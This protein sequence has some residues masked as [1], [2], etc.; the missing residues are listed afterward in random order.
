MFKVLGNAWK[1]ADLRK[2]ILYTLFILLIYRLG[3]VIPVPGTNAAYI[4]SQVENY[5]LLG[6]LNVFSGGGLQNMSIFALGVIP[7][8]NASIIMN[9]LTIAIPAL[10]RMSKEGE[11]GRKKIGRITRYLAVGLGLVQAIGILVSMGS[12]AVQST[13]IFNYITIILCLTAGTALI[14]WLGE[15]INEKGIGNGISLLIF[16]G[17]VAKLPSEIITLCTNVFSGN[18]SAWILVAFV[19]AA[20]VIIAALTF[21]DLGERR[22]PVQYAKRVVGRKQYGGQSTFIPMKVNQSGVMPLIFA[23]T[24]VQIP[25]MIAQFV[26]DSGFAS[27]VNRFLG[28]G[29]WLYA[30]IYFV[31]ILFFSYFYAQ[32]AFNPVD[33]SKNIQQY[34]GFIPGIRPGRPTSDYLARILSRIT[35]FGAIFLALVAAVPTLFS[36]MSGMNTAF[37]ATSLLIMVSVS[38]ETTKQLESQ[39]MMRHYKGFLK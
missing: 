8:I 4:A 20:I 38:L 3:C 29:S 27:W 34:G 31:L 28:T 22:I 13:D 9:L 25:G 1:I 35:L 32:I 26:P 16:I 15:R 17:I 30:V 7:Y 19:I 24:F 36:T 18:T 5:S 37:G 21:V 39:M 2:K 33:V 11:D 10:E 12:Q 23:M 14:M 6:F